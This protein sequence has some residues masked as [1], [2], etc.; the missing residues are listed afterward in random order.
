MADGENPDLQVC[1]PTCAL[2]VTAQTGR[3]LILA[4]SD[5]RLG[6]HS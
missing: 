2:C 1:R 4:R 6:Y 3:T 5:G